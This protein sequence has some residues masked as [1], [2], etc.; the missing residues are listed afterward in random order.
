MNTTTIINLDKIISELRD[1]I[2][3]LEKRV[4]ELE[5]NGLVE[6]ADQDEADNA[7]I[8]NNTLY[9]VVDGNLLQYKSVNGTVF[10]ETL[11]PI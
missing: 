3:R 9:F 8:P 1:K 10:S 5:S 7:N 4:H 6:Y 2:R 11:A